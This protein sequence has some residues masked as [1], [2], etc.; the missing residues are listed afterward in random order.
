MSNYVTAAIATAVAIIVAAVVVIVVVVAGSSSDTAPTKDNPAA[1]TKA[2]VREAIE[3]YH[4]DGREATINYYNS[5][6]SVDG[7]WYVFIVNPDGIT[8]A[9][10]NPQFRGR[11]PASAWTP[12]ATSTVTTCSPLTRTVAG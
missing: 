10:H 5:V 11:D 3:R 1:Y 12:P 9:H 7:Q 6:D 2:F 4:R 8:I